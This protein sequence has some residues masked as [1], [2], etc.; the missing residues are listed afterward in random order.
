MKIQITITKNKEGLNIVGRNDT[1]VNA[2]IPT[3]WGQVTFEQYLK[4]LEAKDDIIK[5]LSV[6]LG[7]DEDMVRK[8]QIKNIAAVT[9][10]L[11]FVTKPITYLTPSKI[12]NYRIAPN[13]DTESIAQYADLQTICAGFIENDLKHNYSLFPL[14]V[15]TYAVNPY[16]FREA[17]KIKDEFLKAPCTEV[18]A[19]GNFT[20]V[21][22]HALNIGIVP[23]SPQAATLL[24]RLKLAL[25]D[26]LL[27]LAST[28]RYYIWKRSLPLNERNYLNG[29]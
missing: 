16:D 19:V 15:A 21:R 8:A 1:I 4:L 25:R 13:L 26:W 17:E 29:K 6:F 12:L 23:T 14:I 24:N 28:L 18:L 7:L 9:A 3:S 10:C 20:L 27:N 2:D 22:L 5:I 11:H